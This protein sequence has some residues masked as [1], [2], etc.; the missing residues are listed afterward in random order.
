MLVFRSHGNND[1]S[2]FCLFVCLFMTGFYSDFDIAP[3]PKLTE[4]TI[5]HN[6]SA[7]F[8]SDNWNRPSQWLM[9]MEPNH[10]IMYHT[11]LI[12]LE[13]LLKLKNVSKV[14][15]VFLTGPDA[16]KQGYN[17]VIT[18][19]DD[20]EEPYKQIFKTGIH[21]LRKPYPNKV[22][23]KLGYKGHV[24]QNANH[25]VPYTINSSNNT[26]KIVTISKKERIQKDMNTTHWKENLASNKKKVPS[27]RCTDHLY[28]NA[29]KQ[30]QY[31]TIG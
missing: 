21:R 27:G 30:Q 2:F 10:P 28:M 14:K 7:F 29:Q 24:Y 6:A 26:T 22:V 5:Q 19:K 13:Q 11:M 8:L 3:G 23:H 16:L 12:I 1:H 20:G 25:K 4:L 31:V 18:T 15:L 17:A 9:G